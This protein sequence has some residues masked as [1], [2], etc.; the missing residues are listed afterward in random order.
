MNLNI[1]VTDEVLEYLYDK[2]IGCDQN[3][4]EI[5]DDF[6]SATLVLLIMESHSGR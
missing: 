4:E 5:T 2:T 1:E 3:C 6:Y